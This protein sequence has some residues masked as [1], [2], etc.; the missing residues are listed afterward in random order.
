[1]TRGWC[2]SVRPLYLVKLS[3]SLSGLLSFLIDHMTGKRSAK[4]VDKTPT[5]QPSLIS[6]VDSISQKSQGKSALLFQL[7]ESQLVKSLV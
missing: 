7:R 2:G 3:L 4:E 5:P 1:M 6:N